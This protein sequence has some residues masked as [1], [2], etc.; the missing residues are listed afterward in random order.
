MPRYARASAPSVE[1]APGGDTL[2]MSAP[3]AR[4]TTLPPAVRTPPAG[5][6]LRDRLRAAAIHLGLSAAG[7][8]AVLALV[9]MGWYPPPMPRLLGVDAILLI[10]LCVDVVLGPLFTL[11]VFDRRK[12]HLKWDLAVV[13]ALQLG[14]LAYGLYAVHQGRPA[15]VVLVKDRFEVVSPAD[16]GREERIAARSNPYASP[17]PLHPRWVAA[18]MPDTVQERSR[19]MLEAVSTG[20]DVQH[21][22]RL[23]VDL[24]ASTRGALEYLLPIERLHTLNRHRGAELLEEVARTGRPA[25]ALGYLPIRGPARDGAVIVDRENARPLLVT[26]FTP[27]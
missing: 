11:I 17:D 23:Y 7:A 16:L 26:T 18:K 14:A 20:R 2:P 22:P 8:C 25:A 3:P 13:A 24:S 6:A 10:M 9:M 27:W 19:I 1:Q 4:A 15:F 21:H 5:G 12:R